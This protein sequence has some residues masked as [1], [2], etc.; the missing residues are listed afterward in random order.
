MMKALQM[1]EHGETG[2][3]CIAKGL[4]IAA[5]IS[6]ILTRGTMNKIADRLKLG[7]IGEL[8]VQIRLLEFDVQAAPPLKDSGNDP[9]AVRG[10][11]VRSI[12]VKTTA[13]EDDGYRIRSAALPLLF[14]VLAIVKLESNET[15]LLLDASQI[16]LLAR[17]DVP[18]GQCTEEELQRHRISKDLVDR[19]FLA[20]P[21]EVNLLRAQNDVPV[22]LLC[23]EAGGGVN[24]ETAP[25]G[26]RRNP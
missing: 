3:G 19:L 2:T 8:L 12:Q 6:A 20:E 15:T 25:R 21:R 7:T 1:K 26:E 11:I 22:N 17:E 18:R 4:Q 14:D 24:P 9:I 5:L 13:L 16:F 10:K 23:A